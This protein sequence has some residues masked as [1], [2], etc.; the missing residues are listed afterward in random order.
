MI[1]P[2]VEQAIR[3]LEESASLQAVV[4]AL[5]DRLR[6]AKPGEGARTAGQVT[7]AGMTRTA[8][9][10]VAAL[11]ARALDRPLLLLTRTNRDA[12]KLVESLRF[13]HQVLT[14]HAASSVSLFP[15][16]DVSPYRGFSPHPDIAE[17]RAVALWKLARGE[18]EIAVMPIAAALGRLA[19]REVYAG[20][21]RTIYPRAEVE[22][23]ELVGYLRS[24][25]YERHEPVEMAGQYS[26][27][28][29]IVDVFPPESQPF[30]LELFGDTVEELRAFDPGT[31][32]STQPLTTA[33]VLPLVEVPRT[34]ELL[35]RL[36]EL[37][38]GREAEAEV[39][40]APFPGWEFLLPLAESLGGT[41]LELAPRAVVLLD[42]P[43]GLREEA[44]QRWKQWEEEHERRRNEGRACPAPG[45]LFFR[46]QAFEAGVSQRA[47]LR[48]EQLALE[49]A[50]A[51][52]FVLA[53]QPA[54]HFRGDVRA[55][56]A[57]LKERLRQGGPVLV[58][59]ATAG[60]SQR[61]AEI[62]SEYE[63]PYRFAAVEG[64]GPK[65]RPDL[66]EEKSLLGAQANAA[67][68]LQGNLAEGVIFPELPLM[69]FGNTDLFDTAPAV[70][71]AKKPRSKAAAFAAD[72]GELKEGDYV[73]HV[74]H[75]IGHF[76]GLKQIAHDGLSEEFLQINYLD[77]DRLY[78]PL[79]RLDLVHK[80]RSLEGVRPKLDRLG[81]ASWQRTKQRAARALREMAG[82][83]L[84]LYAA[85]ATATGHVFSADS[86]WQREFEDSFE[87]EETADQSSAT[88]EV[89]RDME[90]SQPMDRLLVGDVGF[91]KT[92]VALRAAFKAMSDSKQVAVLAP[93]TVLA[94]QHYENFRRRLAP[95]PLRVEMLSRFRSRAE[96]K[97]VLADLEAGKVDLVVGTH[98]LLSPDVRFH[99]L[100]LLV[101]D[102]EQRFGVRH[103]ERLKQLRTHV[104]VLT[105]TATPIPR[106]LHMALTGL[107]DL[108]LIETP[109]S[110]RLAIQTVVAPLSDELIRSAVEQEL[111]REGQVYFVHDRVEDIHEVAQNLHRLVPRARIAVAHGQMRERELERV[112]LGFMGGK[113]DVLVTTKIIE[114][115]LDIP[116][117]NTIIVARADRFGLAELYQ[118]RGRVGRSDRRAYAYLL[119]PP[120]TSLS[121]TARRRLAALKEFSELGSGFRLA[122]LDLELRGAGNL[123]GGQQHG[124]INAIG[125]DLYAQLLERTITELRSGAPLPEGRVTLRLGVD[126]RIPPDYVQDERQRLRLY[127]RI[128][129]LG[130]SVG[131]QRALVAELEDRYGPL[132][133]PVQNL[134]R[135]AGVKALAERLLIESI[136]QRAGEVRVRFHPQTRVR[137]ERLVEFV[138]A[139]PGAHLDPTGV[140][141]FP[142][143][144]SEPPWLEA[145]RKRLLALEG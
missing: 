29:G 94:F 57:D 20:L 108:S 64:A 68:L 70:P 113:L 15:A 134:L 67:V 53:T 55:F 138:G 42:E 130:E 87:W 50:G 7:L 81:G 77:N 145:L 54:P 34:P 133:R 117:S 17:A 109:P 4:R 104:D 98:R 124:H 92:E 35:G 1:I 73:V 93:T 19:G 63:V 101:V 91:G 142:V 38:E 82:E 10:L 126:I 18:A 111:A 75:G 90:R 23:E 58:A 135:Y 61:M 25:G 52:H 76:A 125:F 46:W 14:G 83:L 85:R 80:Y 89:K 97:L 41:V 102:E 128:A 131:E 3:P 24:V 21:G 118:L 95:F 110:D 116:L 136:E 114:N 127:K 72:I 120:G 78:V 99:D 40:V 48:M 137:A 107:R 43:G 44:E 65:A 26:V 144:R 66:L 112:M 139:V 62:L 11:V 143:D 129:S 84:H 32:R 105:L 5:E 51:D 28:G 13:F 74:D 69:L 103:K 8:K 71:G 96:Q 39:E 60:E 88:A 37:V 2:F 119:V 27:R 115:G 16:H 33:T 56:V 140:L 86:P 121:E 45:E 141:R 132:P 9:A 49:I 122:A 100:G 31:Q 12:E 123:L 30:R 22:L 36:W 59:S 47:C 106:T 79:A 6:L